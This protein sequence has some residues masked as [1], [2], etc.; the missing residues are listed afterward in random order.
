[1]RLNNKKQSLTFRAALSIPSYRIAARMQHRR[2]TCMQVIASAEPLLI[3]YVAKPHSADWP[4]A[5]H[6]P[7]VG[8]R[9]RFLLEL[10]N[11]LRCKFTHSIL[12]PN[13]ASN[14][15]SSLHHRK[16]WINCKLPQP[17]LLDCEALGD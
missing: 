14:P 10:R 8:S 15:R 6:S 3:G 5:P 1:M 16:H 4:E 7:D 17:V 13:P 12:G 11:Y 9:I 2:L